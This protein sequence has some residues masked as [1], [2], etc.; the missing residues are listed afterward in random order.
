VQKEPK[1]ALDGGPDGLVLLGKIVVQAK[2]RLKAGG[3]LALEL[4]DEQGAAVQT[5]LTRAEYLDVRIE[6]DLARFDRLAFGRTPTGA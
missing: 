6:K 3:L 5:Q 2:S 4:G 1:L